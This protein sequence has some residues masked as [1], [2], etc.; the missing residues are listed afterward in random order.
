MLKNS[1]YCADSV[2]DYNLCPQEL[3]ISSNALTIR[4][5]GIPENVFFDKFKAFNPQPDELWRCAKIKGRDR[6]N[7]LTASNII[8]DIH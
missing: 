1:G 6:P 2:A 8:Q 3:N 5:I 4:H 7:G